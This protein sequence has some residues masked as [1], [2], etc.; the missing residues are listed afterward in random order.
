MFNH[1]SF[2]SWNTT[3]GSAQFGAL[4][5]PNAMRDLQATLRFR[6]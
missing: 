5:T 1:V 4:Q 3:V 2:G 6:F